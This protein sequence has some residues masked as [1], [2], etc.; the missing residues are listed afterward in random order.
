MFY[1]GKSDH[2]GRRFLD[3]KK[4][5]EKIQTF[6]FFEC[7]KD[8]L[9]KAEQHCIHKADEA[10]AK[11]LNILHATHPLFK[12]PLDDLISPDEQEEWL[13]DEACYF[14]GDRKE[15]SLHNERVRIKGEARF[16]R[17][18]SDVDRDF[19]I[20][21]CAEYTIATILAPFTT[22]CEYWGVSCL[23]STARFLPGYS[24]LFCFNIYRMETFVMLCNDKIRAAHAHI[25]VARSTLRQEFGTEQAVL[26]AYPCA[27]FPDFFYK[28]AGYDQ[29][30]VT[31]TDYNDMH[32]VLS[33]WRIVRAARVMNLRLMKK[34]R[35]LFK[36]YHSFQLAD[37]VLEKLKEWTIESA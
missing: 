20:E 21:I 32:K 28:S 8:N 13:A 11:I 22:E 23:P 35:N 5:Y 30:V 18:Q 24:T 36:Q 37:R 31:F 29:I 6:S 4:T 3:H 27:Y 1:I 33:D 10:G 34:G 2:I 26:D 7:D 15:E 9:D 25:C 19:L 17:F 14:D 12:T 16:N